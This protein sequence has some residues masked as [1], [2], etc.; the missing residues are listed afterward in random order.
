MH[1]QNLMDARTLARLALADRRHAALTSSGAPTAM[2]IDM[3][4]WQNITSSS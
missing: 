1:G 2:A 4:V 3:A